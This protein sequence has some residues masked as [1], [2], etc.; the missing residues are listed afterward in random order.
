MYIVYTNI[1][2]SCK[3]KCR[4]I[5]NYSLLPSGLFA[6]PSQFFP[7][8]SCPWRETSGPVCR[9]W[10]SGRPLCSCTTS[11]SSSSITSDSYS[12]A[13]L[14]A[15][16]STISTRYAVLSWIIT[17]LVREIRRNIIIKMS[18]TEESTI[19]GGGGGG[20]GGMLVTFYNMYIIAETT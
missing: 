20:G 14:T 5:H 8:T 4:V 11:H 13:L 19:L 7:T 10:W 9:R 18:I 17:V 12:P 3:L 15:S 16:N 6:M 1:A 2:Y